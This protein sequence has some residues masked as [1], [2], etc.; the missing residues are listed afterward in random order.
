MLLFLHTLHF[1]CIFELIS[2]QKL[3]LKTFYSL[4]IIYIFKTSYKYSAKKCG[5]CMRNK[6]EIVKYYSLNH[7]KEIFI[8]KASLLLLIQYFQHVRYIK[9]ENF[10]IMISMIIK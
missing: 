3:K 4:L 9:E 1:I 6:V 8:Y 7:K 5:P 10:V 2:L